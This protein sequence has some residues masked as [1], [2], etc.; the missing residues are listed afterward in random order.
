MAVVTSSVV[1]ITFV[2]TEITFKVVLITSSVVKINFVVAEIIFKMFVITSSV[3]KITYEK[4]LYTGSPSRY[5]CFKL[6][7]TSLLPIC[8][9]LQ[10]VAVRIGSNKF[11]PFVLH[12]HLLLRKH[13]NNTV[14]K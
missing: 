2:V 9:S 10:F 3:V 4:W 7:K 6:F 8:S 13:R 5:G 1:K 12:L 11:L 14:S